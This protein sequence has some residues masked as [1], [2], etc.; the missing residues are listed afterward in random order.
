MKGRQLL[1][2]EKGA[3]YMVGGGKEPLVDLSSRAGSSDLPTP[4]DHSDVSD[5]TGLSDESD[6][7]V[8]LSRREPGELILAPDSPRTSPTRRTKLAR[9]T[10][11]TV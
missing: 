3:F 5:Q 9:R 6:S 11:P 10:T 4:S 7:K 2:E 1:K 8:R